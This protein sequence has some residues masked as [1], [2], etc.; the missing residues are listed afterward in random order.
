MK[1]SMK[2]YSVVLRYFKHVAWCSIHVVDVLVISIREFRFNQR[3]IVLHIYSKYLAKYF[4]FMETV[5]KRTHKTIKCI[6]YFICSH[7]KM[8][9]VVPA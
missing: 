2:Q 9:T 6:P 4:V 7:V 5:V 3:N 8:S 1:D